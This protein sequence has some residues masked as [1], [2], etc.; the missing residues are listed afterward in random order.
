VKH[1][2]EVEITDFRRNIGK[3]KGNAYV[4]GELACFADAMFALS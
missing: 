1:F 3:A 4:N 2:F